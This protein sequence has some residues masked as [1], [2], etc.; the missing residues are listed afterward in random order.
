M[1]TGLLTIRDY[2]SAKPAAQ[3]IDHGKMIVN[4]EGDMCMSNGRPYYFEFLADNGYFTYMASNGDLVYGYLR[5]PS[6]GD[7]SYQ[8]LGHIKTGG[9]NGAR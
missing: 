7:P 9:C 1:I 4:L 8:I 2:T 6:W 3:T 5:F